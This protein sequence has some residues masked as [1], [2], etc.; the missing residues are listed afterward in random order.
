MSLADQ[1]Y[2][3]VYLTGQRFPATATS[4]CVSGNVSSCE[5]EVL[6]SSMSVGGTEDHFS[7]PSLVVDQ[8]LHCPTEQSSSSSDDEGSTTQSRKVSPL[9]HSSG[10]FGSTV[11]PHLKGSESTTY[12]PI[13]E[14]VQKTWG[15]SDNPYA[16]M[17]KPRRRSSSCPTS[18][19]STTPGVAASF[20]PR[21]ARQ[22]WGHA[23][24]VQIGE[25]S[26]FAHKPE[27]YGIWTLS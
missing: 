12:D 14:D 7:N 20:H 13:E 22:N 4:S 3:L 5:P 16:A 19:T 26:L 24:E 15:P 9:M 17:P 10:N 1:K 18:P 8:P 2:S 11:I 27:L 23:D 21:Q 6:Q 25:G